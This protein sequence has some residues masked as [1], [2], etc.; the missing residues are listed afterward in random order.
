MADAGPACLTFLAQ[1]LNVFIVSVEQD[2]K[3]DCAAQEGPSIFLCR[4]IY[5][6]I[7]LYIYL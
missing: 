3:T 6:I 4:G 7:K 1:Y 2:V 5:V